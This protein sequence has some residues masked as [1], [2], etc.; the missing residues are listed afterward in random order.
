MLTSSLLSKSKRVIVSSCPKFT[1]ITQGQLVDPYPVS[2]VIL[3]A[4]FPS[5]ATTLYS[6]MV[7]GVEGRVTT[8]TVK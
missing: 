6:P 4:I 2:C 5:E 8:V 3:L 7:Q 1:R